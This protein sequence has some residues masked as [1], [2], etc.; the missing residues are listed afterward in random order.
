MGTSQDTAQVTQEAVTEPSS[1]SSSMP[2][3]MTPETPRETSFIPEQDVTIPDTPVVE[4]K[5]RKIPS[6]ESSKNRGQPR[7]TLNE[8]TPTVT[9]EDLPDWLK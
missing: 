6:S 4:K 3:G 7:A 5:I 1:E 8:I 2:L 9:T